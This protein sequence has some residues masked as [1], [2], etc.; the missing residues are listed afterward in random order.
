MVALTLTGYLGFV[1]KHLHKAL[2][3]HEDL[4][5]VEYDTSYD[6]VEQY[7][8]RSKAILHQGG[9][10]DTL[11]HDANE[12]MLTNFEFSRK[13]FDLCYE[14]NVK[15]IYASTAAAYGS[16]NGIP[17]NIYAWSKYSAEQYG[18]ALFK[19]RPGKFIALRYFNIYGPGEEHKGKMAS[20]AYQALDLEHMK[21]FPNRPTRDFIHIDDIVSANRYALYNNIPNGSYEVGSG[22]SSS[23]EDVLEIL[24]VPYSYHDE[25]AIP[26][27]Y[28][29]HTKSDANNWMPGWKP[30]VSL[31][32]GLTAYKASF[33]AAFPEPA[34]RS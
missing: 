27:G 3:H 19:G 29:F 32:D 34:L 31:Q 11:N 16:G 4:F 22:V 14:H 7:I 17:Q 20:V 5:L 12:M 10:A 13:I 33:R 9:I 26:P 30:A 21:L 2:D 25:S 18:L 6:L 1:G 24:G 8:S 15:V 23:F 28:Q